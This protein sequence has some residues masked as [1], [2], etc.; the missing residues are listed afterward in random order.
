VVV[1][2]DLIWRSLILYPEKIASMK[3]INTIE[4]EIKSFATKLNEREERIQICMEMLKEV[5]K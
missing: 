4:T 1:T 5:N 3:G 2:H